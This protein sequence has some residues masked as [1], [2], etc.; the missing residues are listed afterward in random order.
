[1]QQNLCILMVS[2]ASGLVAE[3][4]KH[5]VCTA[6]GLVLSGLPSMLTVPADLA[7]EAL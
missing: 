5:T 6:S 4:E 7:R 1:M 2:W 3:R